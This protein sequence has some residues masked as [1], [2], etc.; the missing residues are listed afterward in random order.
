MKDF[1]SDERRGAVTYVQPKAC[2]HEN[3][4]GLHSGNIELFA[5]ELEKRHERYQLSNHFDEVDCA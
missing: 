2:V 5:Y 3:R 1:V 4:S